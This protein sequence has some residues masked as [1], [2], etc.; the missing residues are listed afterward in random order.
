MLNC[1]C[2]ADDQLSKCSS[3]MSWRWLQLFADTVQ[4]WRPAACMVVSTKTPFWVSFLQSLRSFCFHVFHGNGMVF[5]FP[6]TFAHIYIYTY[7]HL[8]YIYT[9]Q[10]PTIIKIDNFLDVHSLL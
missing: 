6:Q 4:V 1:L 10:Y 5:L 2:F 3:G 7:T 9:Y 8:I